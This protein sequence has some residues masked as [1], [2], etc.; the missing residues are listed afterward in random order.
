MTNNN[1]EKTDGKTPEYIRKAVKK[2]ETSKDKITIICNKG[3]KERII[4]KYGNISISS[5]ISGLIEKDLNGGGDSGTNT[6]DENNA[7]LPWD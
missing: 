3:T 6:G 7:P 2:Y 4:N 5:Y 1:K